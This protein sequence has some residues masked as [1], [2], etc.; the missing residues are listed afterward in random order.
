MG[1]AHPVLSPP[2]AARLAVG[3]KVVDARDGVGDRDIYVM[4]RAIGYWMGG[5]TGVPLALLEGAYDSMACCASGIG[6]LNGVVDREMRHAVADVDSPLLPGKGN[7]IVARCDVALATCGGE[8]SR[9]G[10]G[11]KREGL[12]ADYGE[13]CS[14]M[15]DIASTGG[16]NRFLG[17]ECRM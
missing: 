14:E 9:K 6:G 17:D 11:E 5:V 2:N 15:D 10:R 12:D 13:G 4:S 8:R 3:R 16:A 1:P 7:I